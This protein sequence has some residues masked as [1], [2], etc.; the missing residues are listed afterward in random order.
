MRKYFYLFCLPIIIFN[1]SC[2]ETR[3]QGKKK[4]SSKSKISFNDSILTKSQLRGIDFIA[5]GNQPQQWNIK[6][7]FDNECY[8]ENEDSL[9][10]KLKPNTK[11]NNDELKEVYTASSNSNKLELTIYKE[12]C[13]VKKYKQ[14]NT[15]ITKVNYNGVTYEGCGHYLF[16][17]RL[18]QTWVLDYIDNEPQFAIN[19]TKGIPYFKINLIRNKIT[20]F[21]GSNTLSSKIEVKGNRILFG[22]LTNTSDNSLQSAALINQFISNHLVDYFFRDNKLVF[23]LA[24]DTRLTFKLKED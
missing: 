14:L 11:F 19:Y 1:S 13:D 6:M 15:S 7:D 8:F 3:L 20:G 22:R 12:K 21:D 18:H 10:I 24:N 5:S 16:D 4:I 23:Q 2:S 17:E 9:I